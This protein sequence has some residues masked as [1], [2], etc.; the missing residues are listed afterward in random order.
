MLVKYC[1]ISDR[2]NSHFTQIYSNVLSA[3]E[4]IATPG[5]C[6]IVFAID[7]ESNS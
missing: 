5:I 4:L 3:I 2:S 7:C 1:G 6:S